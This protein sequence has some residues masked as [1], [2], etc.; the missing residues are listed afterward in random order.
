MG[1]SKI[2]AGINCGV[3]NNQNYILILGK[4][5]NGRHPCVLEKQ[6]S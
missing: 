2:S 1:K 6:A 4:T 5:I 3:G